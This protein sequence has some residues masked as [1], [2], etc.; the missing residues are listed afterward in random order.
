[1][2]RQRQREAAVQASSYTVWRAPSGVVVVSMPGQIGRADCSRV[3]AAL[4]RAIQPGATV[5][6]DLTRA[7][8]CGHDAIVTLVSMQGLAAQ[9]GARLRVAAAA[10]NARLIRQVAGARHR[11]DFYPDLATALIGPRSRDTARRHHR[12]GLSA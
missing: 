5:I 11:L 1:M 9:A 10:P 3:H 2:Q 6:V 7:D 4:T 12:G 8:F